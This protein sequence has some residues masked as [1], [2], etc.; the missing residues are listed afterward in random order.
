MGPDQVQAWIS[1]VQVLASIGVNVAQSIKAMIHAGHP[2]L[3]DAEI[4]AAY[5]AILADD[6]VRGDFAD[7]AS[8]PS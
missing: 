6:V 3:T 5:A 1:V 2:T 8:R 7:R 4:D